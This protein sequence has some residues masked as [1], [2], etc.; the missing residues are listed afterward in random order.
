M[1]SPRPRTTRSSAGSYTRAVTTRRAP[2]RPE[3][4]GTEPTGTEPTGTEPTGTEP[5]GTEPAGTEP[6]GTEP[7]GTEPA[8]TEPAGSAP[9]RPGPVFY[10]GRALLKPLLWL[11]FRPRVSGRSNVPASG[12]VLLVSN[13]QSGL[14][15]I[16]I[17]SFAPR[18]VQFLAKASLFKSPLGGWFFTGIGA[19]PVHRGATSAASAALESGRGV[20]ESGSAFVVFPEG[21]RSRDGR[22]YQGRGGAAWLARATGA[23]VIPVGL[24]GTDRSQRDPKTGRALRVSLTFGAPLNLTD[25]DG[26]PAGRARREATARMMT[27]IQALTGQTLAESFAEGSIG[28]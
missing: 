6:A 8:G 17:P 12:P 22:L 20:L 14:D 3:P 16:L 5:T 23:T 13:H 28:A 1:G 10:I 11:R 24:V 15:T 25:L 2:S 27:A 7:A 19:V 26:L 18:R 4:A 9:A 21:S